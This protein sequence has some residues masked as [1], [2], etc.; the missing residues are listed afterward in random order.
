MNEVKINIDEVLIMLGSR[1]SELIER[2]ISSNNTDKFSQAICAFSNDLPNHRQKGYLLIGVKDNGELSGLKADD[3]LLQNLGGLRADG[4]ILPQPIISI[5]TFSFDKGDVV[6]VEI[7]PSPFPP[8]RFKGKTWIRVGSRKAVASEMEERILIE[9]RSSNMSMF[10]MRP[11]LDSSLEDLDID[12]FIGLYLPKAIDKN[13]L[14]KDN[15]NIKEKLAALRFYNTLYSKPTNAGVLLFGKN[16][17][18]FFPG[19]YIQYVRFEGNTISGKILNEKKFSGSLVTILKKIEGFIDDAIITQR[20]VPFST[21]QEITK[22]NYPNWTIRELMMNAVMHR[23][24]ESNA[25]I[26]FYQFNNSI[27]IANAG[28]LYGKA[29]PENFPNENDYRNPVIAEAMKILGYVNRFNRGIELV[30]V[31]LAE[32]NNPE[33]VFDYHKTTNFA[34][35]VWEPQ[36]TD[37]M[38]EKI[39][40]KNKDDVDLKNYGRITEELRKKYGRN[41][42]EILKIISINPESTAQTMAER[43][44]I[45]VSTIEKTI[46]K[47][48][49]AGII[50]RMGSTKSGYWKITE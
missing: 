18:Y 14:K 4:N 5:K 41:T 39:I 11:C 1:E 34:V 17:E 9:R 47:L 24:Y 36:Q 10:D 12:L 21:L 30:K 22:N 23:D 33:P 48:K 28:G 3:K 6:V 13:I 46:A 43:I 49:K 2:T 50:E 45:S 15:R 35:S 37:N 26:K 29:R 42:E 44:N 19:A 8:V 7:T 38:Q 16:P 20:P 25:P 27:E 31:Q 40:D 32:N